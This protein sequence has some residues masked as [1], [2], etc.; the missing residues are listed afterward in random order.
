L[1]TKKYN[2]TRPSFGCPCY[3]RT[4][5]FAAVTVTCAAAAAAAVTAAV[6]YYYAVTAVP[7]LLPGKAE[8]SNGGDDG[9]PEAA[10]DTITDVLQGSLFRFH[11]H[12]H[13]CQW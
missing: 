6:T 12:D 4:F 11:D 5:A 13:Y 8:R 1:E 10:M 2:P 7:L 9:R 3:L